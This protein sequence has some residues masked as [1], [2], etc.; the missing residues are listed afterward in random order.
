[1]VSV[2]GLQRMPRGRRESVL[3]VR[4]WPGTWLPGRKVKGETDLETTVG[5]VE[6]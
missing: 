6:R 4:A 2:L 3:G 5:H 1:M